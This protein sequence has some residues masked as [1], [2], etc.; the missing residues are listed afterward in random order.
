MTASPSTPGRWGATPGRL[1]RVLLSLL[2]P[3]RCAGCGRRGHWL[4]AGC[5]ALLRPIAPPLCARCGEP[6]PE[7]RWERCRACREGGPFAL[8]IARAAYPFAGPIRAAIHRFKYD[9][10]RARAE[11]LGAALVALPPFLPAGAPPGLEPPLVVPVPLATAR[12][13]E[14]GFNQAEDLARVLAAARGW[15]LDGGLER[16]RAT[17]PQVGLDRAARQENVRGAFVWRG[18]PLTG[19]RILLVDDV[20]TS[21]A[22]AEACA[23]TLK[24]AGAAWVG[25]VAVARPVGHNRFDQP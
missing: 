22:T 15:S 9:G 17:R 7:G 23:V 21:G 5:T 8:D 6:L 18:A 4:C 19:R 10:E 20:F 13:R 3:P 1:S 25:L 2:F 16:V 12:R 11:H 24:A 14:R